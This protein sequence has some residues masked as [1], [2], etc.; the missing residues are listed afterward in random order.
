MNLIKYFTM[1]VAVASICCA[2]SAQETEI[3]RKEVPSAVLA[4]FD[5]AYPT[6]KVLEWEKEIHSGKL[7]YEAETVDGKV[8]R[9]ILYSPDGTIAQTVEKIAATDIPPAVGQGLKR[10]LPNAAIRSAQK[11]T[12]G[13]AVEY[14]LELKGGN[15]KKVVMRADGTIASNE[16]KKAIDRGQ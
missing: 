10:E 5:K 1:L 14:A 9:N 11:V 3:S 12:N 13:Q 16:G 4:S 7:Y 15:Q 6:A 2:V 8:P